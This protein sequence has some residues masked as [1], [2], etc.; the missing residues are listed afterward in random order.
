M[1]VK[2]NIGLLNNPKTALEIYE[3]INNRGGYTV[4]DWK[5]SDGS[6]ASLIEPTFVA[7]VSTDYARLSKIVSDV[8]NLCSVLNQECIAIHASAFDLLVYR[9][10][11]TG[12]RMMF[13]PEYFI[14]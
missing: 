10:N 14:Y 6:Y 8:E 1:I 2:I 5:V 7:R 11:Y 4:L 13:D 12:V 9:I 3:Y